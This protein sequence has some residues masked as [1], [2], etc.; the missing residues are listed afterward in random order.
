MLR[1]RLDADDATERG[2]EFVRWVQ[3]TLNHIL[4]AR[5][6]VDGVMTPDTRRAVRAFQRRRGLPE[7]GIVGPD[8]ERALIA[9][10][11]ASTHRRR[12]T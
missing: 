9:A 12:A 2:T 8:T 11:S 10:R 7:D 4:D 5:L 6:T 1:D 3:T